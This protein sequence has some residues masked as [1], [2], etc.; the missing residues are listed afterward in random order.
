VLE[1][2]AGGMTEAQLLSDFPDLAP[3]DI[4]ASLAFAAAR[5][6]RVSSV[7][8]N[9]LTSACNRRR[10]E[11]SSAAAEARA[12]DGLHGDEFTS[13]IDLAERAASLLIRHTCSLPWWTTRSRSNEPAAVSKYFNRPGDFHSQRRC[14]IGH[15]IV[16]TD[17]QEG[18]AHGLTEDDVR[19]HC[20]A[21]REV[22]FQ[23]VVHSSFISCDPRAGYCAVVVIPLMAYDVLPTPYSAMD[24]YRVVS[25]P[26]APSLPRPRVAR[27]PV[28][29]V[30]PNLAPIV[31][32]SAIEP[33]P[34][35]VGFDRS[36]EAGT[37]PVG[38]LEGEAQPLPP[39]EP[40]APAPTQAPIRPGG[41]IKRPVK[42]KDVPPQYPQIAVISR[43]EGV[44]IIE[45][46]IGVDGKVEEAR[47][48]RSIPLL[49]AAAI[50]AVSQWEF[51]PTLLNDVPVPI[52]MTVTVNFALSR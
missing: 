23:T 43:T 10:G 27:T 41:D 29:A 14:R 6:R 34:P 21:I 2:L 8:T 25:L 35:D 50:A 15:A 11:S 37:P 38:I 7:A 32:P 22:G 48:L 9:G 24:S 5:E 33:E 17:L 42:T 49:D 28:V 26:P 13:Q 30:N 16:C 3:E 51:T 45:A 47:V 36:V 4:R 40:P 20:R 18:D 31:E 19:R 52:I 44:V 46:T 12:L 1:Y 39:P